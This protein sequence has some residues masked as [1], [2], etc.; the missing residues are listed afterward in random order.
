LA[1]DF[2]VELM[3]AAPSPPSSFLSW[4]AIGRLRPFK[5]ICVIGKV[6]VSR[7]G[8]K[9]QIIDKISVKMPIPISYRNGS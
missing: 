7:N 5:L 1:S 6:P 2:V 4:L 8:K 9:Y 3:E